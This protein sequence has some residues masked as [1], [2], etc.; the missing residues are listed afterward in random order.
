MVW[1]EG[2][3]RGRAEPADDGGGWCRSCCDDEGLLLWGA[4]EEGGAV[5]RGGKGVHGG[6]VEVEDEVE[7][8][9]GAGVNEDEDE[10]VEGLGK[11][12]RRG[13][14]GGA[15]RGVRAAC[16]L[17]AASSRSRGEVEHSDDDEKGRGGVDH[18]RH[19]ISSGGPS[20]NVTRFL[21]IARIPSSGCPRFFIPGRPQGS[22]ASP[23]LRLINSLHKTICS[24]GCLYSNFDWT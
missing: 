3:G 12:W 1:E 11:D 5:A 24:N 13:R 19:G 2:G 23:L 20:L 8:A 9:A 15:G 22:L 4:V 17:A 18:G 16:R 21:M 7:E 6:C 10:I 14:W